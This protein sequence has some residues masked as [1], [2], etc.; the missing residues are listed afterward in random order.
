MK[1]SGTTEIS[2][3]SVTRARTEPST[4]FTLTPRKPAGCS[5]LTVLFDDPQQFGRDRFASDVIEQL[6][7]STLQP[8]I[9]RLLGLPILG[10]RPNR[11]GLILPLRHRDMFHLR[12]SPNGG[13]PPGCVR[14]RSIV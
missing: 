5:L 6:V 3:S 8:K 14:R 12:R 7:Q 2:K 11:H 9:E 10:R 13:G 1:T 4:G